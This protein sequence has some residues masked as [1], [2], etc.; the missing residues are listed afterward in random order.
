MSNSSPQRSALAALAGTILIWA[1]SWVVPRGVV[2][3]SLMIG[4]FTSFYPMRLIRSQ[5]VTL[6]SAEFVDAG[7]MIGASDLRILRR[8]LFPHLVPSLLVWGAIAVGTNIL[9][10]VSLSFIGVGVEPSTPTWGSSLAAVWGTIYNPRTTAH[11]AIWQTVFPTV[12]ILITV[13]AL[14]QLS[15]G[16]RR[17]LEPSRT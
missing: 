4:V 9:V 10:E 13:V 11:P 12:A 8:H 1:Y 5:L 15:E 3:D 6:R 7:H 2:A 14:N 17:A 16:V